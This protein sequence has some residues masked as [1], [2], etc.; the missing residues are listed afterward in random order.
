MVN[1]LEP[2]LSSA[3]TRGEEEEATQG[4]ELAVQPAASP[5]QIG[6]TSWRF[7]DGDTIKD[8]TT[9]ESIRLRGI[10]TRETSK[11][12]EESG[13]KAGE[14]GGDAATAYIWDLAKKHGFNRVIRS[15]EEGKWGREVGDLV[16]E[17]GQSFVDTLLVTGV[18]SPWH[19]SD[20]GDT[21]LARWGLA[22]EAA[23]SEGEPA[24]DW[25]NARQAIYSAET[26]Q[27]GGLPMEKLIAFNAAEYQANPD[28]FMGIKS[29]VQGA[30]YEGRSR[31]PFGTGYDNGFAVLYKS[32]NRVGEA[33]A[34]RFGAEDIENTF[35]AKAAGQQ[36][37]I[38]NLPTVKMDVTEIDWTSFDEVTDGLSGILGTSVPFMA[39]TMVGM[40]GSGITMGTSLTLPASMYTG[41]VLDSMEGPVEEKNL[42]VA[43]SA[44]IG[45][46]V[47][48]RMGLKGLVSP[49]LM[50]TKAGRE[51]VIKAIAKKK[52]SHLPPEQARAM[53]SAEFLSTSKKEMVGL[54][55]DAKAFGASQLQKGHIFREGVKRM[56][57]ATA[58]EGITEALQ[59]LTEY[60]A[61]VIGS[62]KEW[63][64]DEIQHSMTNAIIAGGIM[65]AGFASPGVASQV[66]G[67]KVAADSAS[68]YDGR[69]D[70]MNTEAE[71]ALT[72]EY[73]GEMP[74]IDQI[75]T[76][77]ANEAASKANSGLKGSGFVYREDPAEQEQDFEN[78]ADAHEPPGSTVEK[79]KAFMLNPMVTLRA[80]ANEIMRM[81]EGKSKTLLG[82][83]GMVGLEYGRSVPG[84]NYIQ[85][86]QQKVTEITSHI[87]EL[88]TLHAQFSAPMTLSTM[89]KTGYVSDLATRFERQVKTP[90]AKLNKPLDWSKADADLVQH[91]DALL[92]LDASLQKMSNA[93]LAVTNDARRLS[94]EKNV[95]KLDNWAYRHKSFRREYIA[96]HRDTFTSL[97]QSEYKMTKAEATELT[98]S[99]INNESITTLEA[100]FDITKGGV[101]PSS[102]KDRKMNISDKPA[103][104]AFLEQN[105]FKNMEDASREAAR[106]SGQRTYLGKDNKHLTGSL[107]KVRAEFEETMTP[108]AADKKV[109]KIAYSLRNVINAESGNYNP[110][111]NQNIKQGQKWLTMAT[112]LQA[113]GL[114]AVASTVEMPLIVHGVPREIIVKN[115]ATQGYLFGSALGSYIRNL[116]IITRT[117]KPRESMDTYLDTKM[118]ELRSK[119]DTDP[120]FLMYSNLKELLKQSGF[121]A[122][123]AGAATT[124]GV[125]DTN[126]LTRGM[127][128]S[129]FKANFMHDQQDMHRMMR[130][131]FFNDFLIDKIDIIQQAEGQT[132]TVAV[133]EARQMLKEIGI[134]VNVMTK[135]G[136]KMKNLKEGEEL[137]QKDADQYKREFLNGASNFVNQ[138]IPMPN[139]AN[140]PLFYSDPR[141]VLLT[142]FNGFTSTFT[143]NQLPRLWKQVKGGASKGLQYGTVAAMSNML[144]FAFMSQGLKDELKYGEESP[145]LTDNQRIQRAIF[146]S[147]LLGTTERVIGSNFMFPL[148]GSDT[149]G[150]GDFV[151]ENVAGEAAAAGTVGKAYNMIAGAVE[152]DDEKV[153]RNFVKSLPFL[154]PF[155]HNLLNNWE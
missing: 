87:P 99:I 129:F 59:E 14:A 104:D 106:F 121:K 147:G 16:N 27:Y 148:Y 98:D 36:E 62:E 44:G 135:L 82:L 31:T 85:H 134:P 67:W 78:L 37:Y 96:K 4:P 76:K 11:F 24:S 93:H 109:K 114:S 26:D 64:Y 22:A 69:F 146:S 54:V 155:S 112:T 142:Q 9:G 79:I 25:E 13:F 95:G 137:S 41:M 105:I 92:K 1:G 144:L 126:E 86:L 100:A 117:A 101:R 107:A 143:A 68:D 150:A 21:D 43:M 10:N 29:R 51:E 125:Q 120:R 57:Q 145:Y 39:A 17:E 7:L 94:G 154:G 139:A 90:A 102:S 71:A 65:G 122:Q 56:T 83:A 77:N 19:F 5:L 66:G 33:L 89:G 46:M 70:D 50:V 32:L 116:Q 81:G 111:L 52:Y 119:Q 84:V 40:A 49:K 58:S 132:E 88:E 74:T 131:S 127:M 140:R 55:A 153:K 34:N 6:N 8:D 136:E 152:S 80:E 133:A 53:A 151:W 47:M 2:D 115:A 20:K 110:I 61:A 15:G 45:M 63:N 73:D 38:D 3:L 149:Y 75:N 30:D 141:F 60:T 35:A 130:L 48:D 124:T 42:G 123:Q 23:D 118:Q 28:L 91:K 12:L 103:F 18:A 72:E 97:L 128:D 108:E 113:L 138:A